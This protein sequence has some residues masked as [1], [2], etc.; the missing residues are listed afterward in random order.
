MNCQLGGRP[1]SLASHCTSLF[2]LYQCH[3]AA[4]NTTVNTVLMATEVNRKHLRP[5]T[6]K[7]VKKISRARSHYSPLIT[8]AVMARLSFRSCVISAPSSSQAQLPSSSHFPCAPSV[9]LS[10]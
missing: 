4:T 1:A 7:S 5:V 10:H 3:E 2:S 6:P 9:M 8:G